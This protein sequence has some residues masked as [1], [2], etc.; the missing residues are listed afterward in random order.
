MTMGHHHNVISTS[1]ASQQLGGE[2][3]SAGTPEQLHFSNCC[4]SEQSYIYRRNVAAATIA[5]V[6]E[7]IL[8]VGTTP[9]M[10]RLETIDSGRNE[11]PAIHTLQSEGPLDH[12]YAGQAGDEDIQ[13]PMR[14]A[15]DPN[16]ITDVW[17]DE[18]ALQYIKMGEFSPSNLQQL[19]RD[20]RYRITRRCKCYYM[21]S[22]KLFRRMSSGESKEVPPPA[23]RISVA[24]DIHNQ[25]GHF[26]RRRTTHLLMQQ[27]WWSGMYSDVLKVVA[28][29]PSCSRVM[30]SNFGARSP[31]LQPLPIMGMF[32]RWH[33]D[34][35]GPFP[36]TSRGNAYVMVCVE[37]F[38]KH[39]ELI[40]IPSKDADVTA[41]AFLHNVIARF[42]ACAEVVTDQGKEWD[43][44]FYELLTDCFIDHR[45]TSANRPQSNG[46]A[47]RCV[48][49]LKICLRKQINGVK[50]G[51]EKWDELVAWVALGY[52]VTPHSSTKVAPYQ[53]LYATS[54]IIPPN[55]KARI[56]DPVCFDSPEK[57][58]MEIARRAA[59][60]EKS[61]AIAGWNAL[62]AQHQDTLRYSLI[63]GGAFIPKMKRYEEG[64]YVY[65]KYRT[66]PNSLQPQV[67]PEI[68]RV[69]QV[70]KGKDGHDLVLRL[71]G[72]DGLTTD[73]HFSNC[74]PCHLPIED[75]TL[76]MGKIPIDF[77]CQQCGFPDD[78][79]LLVMCDHCNQGWHTYCMEPKLSSVPEGKW[80]CK[81]CAKHPEVLAA[82]QA[83]TSRV[84]PV[85][86]PAGTPTEAAGPSGPSPMA[87]VAERPK[88]VATRSPK[89]KSIRWAYPEVQG[90]AGPTGDPARIMTR[91]QR[92]NEA[93]KARS[94]LPEHHL[95]ALRQ[96]PLQ[97]VPASTQLGPSKATRY[98]TKFKT[99]EELEAYKAR[100][101]AAAA[102]HE[103]H[104]MVNS[105]HLYAIYAQQGSRQVAV[106]I[107]MQLMPG[108]WTPRLTD[109]WMEGFRHTRE[110][111]RDKPTNQEGPG[112]VRYEGAAREAKALKEAIDF[113]SIPT[114]WDPFSGRC[115]VA[116]LIGQE[117]SPTVTVHTSDHHMGI[118]CDMHLNGLCS[119]WVDRASTRGGLDA[120][121]T[122]PPAGILDLALPMVARFAKL[123]ACC[124]VPLH[125]ITKAH[126]PRAYWLRN[127]HDEGRLF[128]I[129]SDST[130]VPKGLRQVWIVVFKTK[131]VSDWL[132]KPYAGYKELLKRDDSY[133]ENP[134]HNRYY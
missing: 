6:Q 24:T 118:E 62:I 47:E 33:V 81:G 107:L 22:G 39:A 89:G 41:H 102:D 94:S 77:H 10:G 65:V 21:V 29:C 4:D 1:S 23:E 129:P 49:T 117:M 79:K 70:R 110:I 44:E 38:S 50:N 53:M 7:R 3:C 30:S 16:Y 103:R 104:F 25:T 45:R 60:V 84:S 130:G 52:R 111:H 121:V 112:T 5:D 105:D 8:S 2:V 64:D 55:I 12:T 114:T 42:G 27:Y 71:Q 73:E 91:L 99:T 43:G 134:Q 133:T 83:E 82:T 9:E 19:S 124:Q 58:A 116:R 80:Y 93:D 100:V 125:Y 54:P 18:L 59:E 26:G 31:E 34:L 32:Y 14:V 63:R 37:A 15:S 127:L 109:Q 72:R 28:N 98:P 11:G 88:L 131:A 75:E 123:V 17:M 95:K 40:P 67:R 87:E 66:K 61:C 78:E 115:S 74:V 35:A 106:N 20:E 76:Q 56:A 119:D 96:G 57:A 92:K 69:L 122:S 126:D 128:F 86:V 13:P 85:A 101:V 113:S 108:N 132:R 68:L 36:T 46:L 48:Q 90:A 120:I 51:A 97:M